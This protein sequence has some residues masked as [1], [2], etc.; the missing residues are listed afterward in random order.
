MCWRLMVKTRWPGLL[1]LQ[2]C[3]S[4]EA[5]GNL[6]SLTRPVAVQ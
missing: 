3:Q 2:G 6:S 4:K 1:L 5:Q